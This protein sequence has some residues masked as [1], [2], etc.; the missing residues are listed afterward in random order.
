MNSR[1]VWT[2]IV[3]TA[4]GLVV[5]GRLPAAAAHN[6]SVPAAPVRI[7]SRTAVWAS[8]V[9]DYAGT[10]DINQQL[11]ATYALGRKAAP[12]VITL[13][14]GSWI[15]G[16]QA[17]TANAASVFAQK[18]WQAFNLSYRVGPDVT[19]QQQVA[20]IL[21]A[22][23]WIKAHAAQF[24][25]DPNRAV[26]YGFSAG[27]H[28]A[29]MAGVAGGFRAVVSLSGVLQP[30]R[31]ADDAQGLRPD[32]EPATPGEVALYSREAAMMGCA[33]TGWAGDCGAAW[34]AFAPEFGLTSASPPFYI[35][36][37]AD[38]TVVPPATAAAFAYHVRAAGG[39][40]TVTLVAGYGHDDH[41]VFA[42]IGQKEAMLQWVL[43]HDG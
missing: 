13:H 25:I 26:V 4:V 20:D 17:N 8:E 40:A 24:G 15:N 10:G 34:R 39:T 18:G 35:V 22:R 1:T 28:L 2:T 3:G 11:T 21:T 37:G 9:Y 12:W 19:Y 30:H 42:S 31:V 33:F 38:D 43:A 29:A 6:A 23:D 41:E 7:V 36:Q 5:F 16:S 27:G 32:T 14:G